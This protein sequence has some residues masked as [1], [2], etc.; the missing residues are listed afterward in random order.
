MPRTTSIS[1]ICDNAK[2]PDTVRQHF[3]DK[4]RQVFRDASARAVALDAALAEYLDERPAQVEQAEIAAA[5]E[6]TPV[7]KCPK[8]GSNMTIKTTHQD[9]RKYI[10]C[11]NYPTCKNVIWFPAGVEQAEV[12]DEGCARVCMTT[13]R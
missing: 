5:A 8:C 2:Q 4:Y 13:M 11:M 3:I 7:L 9:G 12:L 6:E 10:G 1:R